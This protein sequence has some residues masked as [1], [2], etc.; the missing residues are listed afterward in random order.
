MVVS[1]FLGILAGGAE[2]C[3]AGVVVAMIIPLGSL[4]IPRGILVRIFGVR[5]AEVVVIVAFAVS[6]AVV[7]ASR[8]ASVVVEDLVGLDKVDLLAGVFVAAVVAGVFVAPVV[9]FEG[10]GCARG[11]A[12][13]SFGRCFF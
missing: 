9:A 7:S 5:G 4:V 12:F 8:A 6:S 3:G 10:A 2:A 13:K 1:I 11:R